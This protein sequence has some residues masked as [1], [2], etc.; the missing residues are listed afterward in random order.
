MK[1]AKLKK[2]MEVALRKYASLKQSPDPRV[3]QEAKNAL[4]DIKWA[5]A[6]F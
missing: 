3:A 2:S 1:K 6:G 4:A 5:L